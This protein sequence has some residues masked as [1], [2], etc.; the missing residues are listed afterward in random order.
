MVVKPLVGAV[1]LALLATACTDPAEKQTQVKP[2]P[3]TSNASTPSGPAPAPR[4]TRVQRGPVDG[5]HLVATYGRYV[6][7]R[8]G[9]AA[10]TTSVVDGTSQKVVVRHRPP[11][12]FVA[13]SPVILDG[14]YA[15]IEEI[16]SEGPSPHI[17]AYRYDLATGAK[18]DL[19]Q[20][21]GFP[22]ITEPE[23]GANAGTFAYTTTDAQQQSCLVVA[24]LA[25]LATRVVG[26]VKDPGYL[27]DP[28]VSADSVTF[29]EITAPGTAKR[30]K[31][32]LTVPLVGGAAKSV[33]PAKPCTQWS[34]GT[35]N[36]ATVWSELPGNSANQY[37][38]QAYLRDTATARA[39]RVGMI[40]TDTIVPCGS[41]IY[42]EVR[43]VKAGVESYQIYRWRSGSEPQQVYATPPDTALS[44]PS[45][46]GSRLLVESAYLGAGAKYA[47]AMVADAG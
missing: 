10:G 46:Q 43:Q 37:Q 34:G 26:C 13:Q 23:I 41:W 8:A 32:L 24:K 35:V 21:K 39:E 44:A 20:T 47:D 19:G 4:W 15:L 6:V 30:C 17:R 31:R 16:R 12:G 2:T 3:T 25:T 11:A 9:D 33:V 28:V 1:A 45:C 36:G 5:E 27:A 22:R 42:W 40:L 38:S 29:S 14:R 7:R 18:Q